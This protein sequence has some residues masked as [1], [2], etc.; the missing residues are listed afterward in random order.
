MNKG[1]GPKIWD[2]NVKWGKSSFKKKTEKIG[3]E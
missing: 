1:C 3:L 2:A